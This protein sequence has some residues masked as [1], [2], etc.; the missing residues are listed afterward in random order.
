MRPSLARVVRP[1]LP[2]VLLVGATR[3]RASRRQR[4]AAWGAL[5][6]LWTAVYVRYRRAGRAWTQHEHELLRTATAEAFIR[7]YNERVPT[8]EEEFAIWGL[9]HQHR[10]EMRYELVADAVRAALPAG[11]RVLD[12]GCG[13]GLVADRIL[14]IPATYVGLDFPA[15][16]IAYTRKRFEAMDALLET[17]FLRGDGERLP[18]RDEHFDVVVMSEVIEHLLR[19]ERAV[20][21]VA[22][23]LKPRGTYVITT[24][25]ASEVPLRSP[26]SHLFAWIEKALGAHHPQLISWRPWVWPE[27]VDPELLPDGAPPVYLPHTHHIYGELCSLL[28]AAGLDAFQH[29]TFEFPP[30]QSATA[31]WLERQGEVGRRIVDALELAAR[32][33]PLVDRLGCHLF[34]CARK[35]RAPVADRPPAW[36]WRGPFS[37]AEQHAATEEP[38][39]TLRA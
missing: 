31:A 39:G 15:H 17:L 12:L 14:D 30:P 2:A 27:P 33:T 3:P 29:A 25:N 5:L 6:A 16:H 22:R 32:R 1:G 36:V 21:E 10:H 11:G 23:V 4:T 20:W 26:L 18:V 37:E 9:Y 7:H 28:A 24:N 38:L 34:V 8:I 13:S 35:T 19:P